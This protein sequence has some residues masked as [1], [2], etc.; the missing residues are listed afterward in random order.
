[1][2]TLVPLYV[3]NPYSADPNVNAVGSAS[4]PLVHFYSSYWN[5]L[6]FA[7]GFSVFFPWCFWMIQLGRRFRALFL[8]VIV[9]PFVLFAIYWGASHSGLMREG[10]HPRFFTLFLFLIWGASRTEGMG[11]RIAS[12][13]R[14]V[15]ALRTAEVLGMLLATTILP[16]FLL[17]DPQHAVSDA[18]SL[19]A[20]VGA[21]L[22]LGWA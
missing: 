15:Q 4:S 2:S 10:L 17:L 9:V 3:V 16:K 19:A 5:T 18:A 21:S 6:P 8:A 1:V 13:L 14:M 12:T 7:I 22:L 11:R 20:M